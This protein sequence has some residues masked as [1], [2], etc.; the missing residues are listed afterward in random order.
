[1]VPRCLKCSRFFGSFARRGN[2]EGAKGHYERCLELAKSEVEMVNVV[3]AYQI[4]EAGHWVY[5]DLGIEDQNPLRS[6]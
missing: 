3:Q 6:F 4:G 2:L 1:M 5:A